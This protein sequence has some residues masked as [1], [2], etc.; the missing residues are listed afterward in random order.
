LRYWTAFLIFAFVDVASP[1][2][3]VWSITITII[4]IVIVSFFAR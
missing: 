1:A 4:V 2:H 3:D